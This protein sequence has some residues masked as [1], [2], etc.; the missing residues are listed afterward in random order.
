[1]H[2]I[3]PIV[4][5]QIQRSPLKIGEKPNRRYVTDP[6]LAVQRVRIEPDG[7]VASHQGVEV[8]DVHHRGHPAT[9]NDAGQNGLS[10]GFTS[11]Y[12]AMEER[13]GDHMVLGC[14]GENL[15]VHT[16]RVITL[17]ELAGGVTILDA[18]GRTK[19]SLS[20]VQVAV[21]CRPF[22]GF[23][24]KGRRVEAEV[25]KDTLQFL[26]DGLRGFYGII[27][28]IAEVAVGDV[29]ATG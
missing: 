21:P 19:L 26:H 4:R 1:M 7:I 22:A 29:L 14:A 5:L 3:G 18:A 13:F 24:L 16:D 17:D 27:D 25:M 20:G 10:V 28:G 2:T 6:I 15:I 8:I 9:R 23:A 11:H 12:R